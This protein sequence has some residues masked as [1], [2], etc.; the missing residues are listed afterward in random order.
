MADMILSGSGIYAIINKVN[1]KR[2]IG[3]AKRLH[4]RYGEHRRLLDAGRHHS[5]TLQ[6]SWDKYGA[7]AFE[8]VVLEFVEDLDIL[9]LREQ[10][11]IDESACVGKAG[12]NIS[13]TAGSPLGVKHSEQARS[14]MRL[15]KLGRTLSE[16]HKSRI[17]RAGVGRKMSAEAIERRNSARLAN[18]GFQQ[19][20]E[21]YAKMVET[22]RLRGGFGHD[23][24]ARAKIR[25]GMLRAKE[26]GT[27]RAERGQR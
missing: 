26:Q 1:G 6:R 25:D 20:P 14:N 27:T 19:T 21:S 11:W 13:P 8:Y 3:S 15:A 10:A 17:A 18:G 9:L 16:E 23:D 12:Y 4:R 5:P 22:R 24:A 7:G 2:Y